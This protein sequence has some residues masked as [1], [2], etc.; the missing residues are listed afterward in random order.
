MTLRTDFRASSTVSGACGRQMPGRR[1][2]RSVAVVDDAAMSRPW[3]LFA[4]RKG[5]VRPMPAM[6]SSGRLCH[7]LHEREATGAVDKPDRSGAIAPGTR[8]EISARHAAGGV[9]AVT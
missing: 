8:N 2:H 6:L 4:R 7:C 9:S 5:V 3:T 1:A